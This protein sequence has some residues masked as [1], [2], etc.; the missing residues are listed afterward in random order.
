M[1]KVKPRTLHNRTA[2]GS[3]MCVAKT[4]VRNDGVFLLFLEFFLFRA[5]FRILPIF[6]VS[7]A[8]AKEVSV[9]VSYTRMSYPTNLVIHTVI[10]I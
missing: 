4:R 5:W 10:I 7:P 3:I 2:V 6:C 9:V 1:I 8:I